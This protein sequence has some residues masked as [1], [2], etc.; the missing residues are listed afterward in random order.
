MNKREVGSQKENL[1]ISYLKN[2]GYKII[3]QNFYTKFGEIDVIA[4]DGNTL[5]FIEVRSRSY[6]NL[7]LPEESIN[8]AKQKKII[9]TAKIFLNSFNIDYNEIRFDVIAILNENINH[10]ENAFY[11]E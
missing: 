8:K 7:G 2:K 4:K 1:A 11:L 5:V 6:D 3:K 9:K 10:I